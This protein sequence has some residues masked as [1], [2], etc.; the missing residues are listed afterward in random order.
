MKACLSRFRTLLPSASGSVTVKWVVQISGA[1]TDVE[2]LDATLA[3]TPLD[4]CL[5]KA[6]KNF[7][8]PRHTGNAR[9]V[10]LPFTYAN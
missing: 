7:R 6:V 10:R 9:V 4:E 8:F 2:V 5:K 3:G 1:V